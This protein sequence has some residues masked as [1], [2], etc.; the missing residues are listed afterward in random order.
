MRGDD[1][2]RLLLEEI[3]ATSDDLLTLAGE[4]IAIPSENPPGD[5]TTIGRYIEQYLDRA[6]TSPQSIDGGEGRLHVI[7]RRRKPS[8]GSG[9]RHLA[10]VGHTDVVPVGDTKRWDFP[11]FAGDVV[12][13]HL[14]GRGA[15]DMKAGLAALMHVYTLIHRLNIELDGDLSLVAV[16]DEEAGGARG[17]D[18]LLDQGT[19][20]DVT[21][22]I[23]GEPAER[24]HPTIGQKGS[25]WF[26]LT[27]SG[28]PG[29][30]SLQPRHGVSANLQAA[31]AILALQDLWDLP[32][33]P[34][35]AVADLIERSKRF[36]EEREGYGPGIGDVFEH[37]TINVGTIHGGTSTNVVADS[38]VVN[39]DTRVP[40]GLTRQEV[41]QHARKILADAGI[42]GT[43]E[44]T[45]FRSEPNWTDPEEPIVVDLVD[46]VRE[47]SGDQTAEGVLQWASS[48]ARTFRSHGIPV[49]QYGPAELSTIHGFNE[50]AP[51][52]DIVLAAK[53]YARTLLRYL[54]SSAH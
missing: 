30:G 8:Q 31:R 51:V 23:I 43:I 20:D 24:T 34:P 36:A 7:S 10:L 29:H 44:P 22:A 16:P 14:R 40:I 41:L 11:P 52:K 33:S 37:V 50:R 17:A 4:M 19:L 45:G 2:E 53:V 26:Q 46:A 27:I 6:D 3:E 15:S 25:N 21:S 9:G 13:E 12:D 28:E 39:F 32:T 18:W 48:D 35:A 1:A 49:L 42:N 38:C 54:G 47:L 5:C